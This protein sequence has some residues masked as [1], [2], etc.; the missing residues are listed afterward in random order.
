MQSKLI[1]KVLLWLFE[2]LHSLP[3]NCIFTFVISCLFQQRAAHQKAL[4]KD[5]DKPKRPQTAYFY[6]LADFREKYKNKTLKEGEKIP[7]MAGEAWRKLSD[8]DK[9]PY[10]EKVA[11]D[12]KRYEVELA[13]YKKMVKN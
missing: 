4:G 6:F 13:K 12:R 8:K 3:A 1:S 10:N 11:E 2:I 7:S 5:P 9:Q